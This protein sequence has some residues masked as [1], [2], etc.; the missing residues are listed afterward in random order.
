MIDLHV[1]WTDYLGLTPTAALGIIIAT[2]VLYLVFTLLVHLSG[3]RLMAT[4][5][6]AGFVILAVVGGLSARSMLGESPTMLGGVVALGTLLVLETLTRSLER[7]VRGIRSGPRPLHR[8]P[9][10]VMVQGRPL[11][12]A[13]HRL[14]LTAP[15]LAER[16]R[17]AG[18]REMDDAALVIL[19]NRGTLTVLRRGERIQADL[20]AGVRG[21][22]RVPPELI[23]A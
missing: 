4:P 22:D 18:V 12:E 16:L 8:Y 21:A 1:L 20:L 6:V 5:R 2:V 10:V 11:P 14:H 23:E 7:A 17:V 19:E 13:L 15:E 3:A 9:S